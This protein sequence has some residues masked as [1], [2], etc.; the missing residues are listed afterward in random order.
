MAD[1]SKPKGKR[2]TSMFGSKKQ[3]V[4]HKEV[5]G[6][7]DDGHD[8]DDTP[9]PILDM[10]DM[11]LLNISSR[12]G[13][14]DFSDDTDDTDDD[15]ASVAS[16]SS[17]SIVPGDDVEGSPMKK[18]SSMFSWGASRGISPPRSAGEPTSRTSATSAK[19]AKA[20]KEKI[21]NVSELTPDEIDTLMKTHTKFDDG[22]KNAQKQV[23]L[24]GKSGKEARKVSVTGEAAELAKQITSAIT[25]KKKALKEL[26]KLVATT[27]S[28][29]LD[30]AE[31]EGIVDLDNESD[32]DDIS[33]NSAST[34]TSPLSSDKSSPLERLRHYE[35]KSS[36]LKSLHTALFLDM[37]YP[38]EEGWKL[39]IY[40]PEEDMYMGAKDVG[41]EKLKLTCNVRS[42]VDGVTLEIKDLEFFTTVHQ[43]RFK[44]KSSTAKALKKLMSPEMVQL[45]IYGS[46]LIH[47]DFLPKKNKWRTK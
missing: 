25:E 21:T 15:T 8:I 28:S 11:E 27:G 19:G 16:S 30:Q 38:R 46:I 35:W 41:V 31:A 44:G 6:A 37:Y 12:A 9:V 3:L 26:K 29:V 20:L 14:D 7:D 2:L 42:G 10:S 47:A 39:R 43:M 32:D 13:N 34:T 18:R 17:A 1:E 5:D 40:I 45:G 22:L 23:L 33:V 24:T 36:L 4:T